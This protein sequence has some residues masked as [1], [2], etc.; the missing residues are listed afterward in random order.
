MWIKNRKKLGGQ[1]SAAQNNC[2]LSF[3]P[4]TLESPHI[5]CTCL[6]NPKKQSSTTPAEGKG[7]YKL[8]ELQE[9]ESWDQKEQNC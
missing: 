3:L 1:H 4:V 2:A 8:E 5:L 6:R 9:E 7:T